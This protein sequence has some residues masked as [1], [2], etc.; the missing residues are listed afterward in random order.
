MNTKHRGF[1]LIELLVVIGIIG[2]LATIIIISYT[3]AMAKSR[4]SKRK[5][6]VE[7]ITSAVRL[8]RDDNKKYPVLGIEC[9]VNRN[10]VNSTNLSG[11]AEARWDITF[12]NLI[13][14]YLSIPLPL[15]P[16]NRRTSALSGGNSNAI[17]SG[18]IATDADDYYYSYI[19]TSHSFMVGTRLEKGNGNGASLGGKNWV[20]PCAAPPAT[21]LVATDPDH[22]D[23][24]YMNSDNLQQVAP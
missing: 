22:L 4:D 13:G 1:T 9:N 10:R 6:D 3:G 5:G 20:Q 12:Q 16:I 23:L 18:N 11:T 17:W 2:A 24:L 19:G 14:K 8:Y 7:V 15:D 21:D